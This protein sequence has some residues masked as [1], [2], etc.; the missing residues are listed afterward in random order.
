LDFGR[1]L[2]AEKG[3]E[4]WLHYAPINDIERAKYA[5]LP[6]RPLQLKILS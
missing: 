2:P 6:A 1:I 5:A 4:A 3:R